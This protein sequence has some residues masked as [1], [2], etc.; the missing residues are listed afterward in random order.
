MIAL[1]GIW[2]GSPLVLSSPGDGGVSGN[3][4]DDSNTANGSDV[5]V[6]F[7]TLDPTRRR[8]VVLALQ[9]LSSSQNARIR[10][11]RERAR[12]SRVLAARLQ[13]ELQS[14]MT[15]AAL[16]QQQQRLN[17]MCCYQRQLGN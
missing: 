7:R 2:L 3:P 12:V 17:L 13:V 14:L 10:R 4:P 16:S 15:A 11:S 8:R 5:A 9:L 6:Y 1:M